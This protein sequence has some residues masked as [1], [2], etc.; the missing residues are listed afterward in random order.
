[1]SDEYNN[2]ISKTFCDNSIR[3]VMMIDD[4]FLPYNEFINHLGNSPDIDPEILDGTKRAVKLTNFFHAKKLICDVDNGSEHMDEERVRK[5][6]LL[7]LDYHL[8][9]EN[10]K[11]SLE[12]LSKLRDSKHMN[13]VVIYTAEDLDKTWLQITASL[14]GTSNPKELVGT[15]QED[16]WGERTDEGAQLPEEWKGVVST[17][18]NLLEYL[19]TD[20]IPREATK[21]LADL[22]SGNASQLKH[23]IAETCLDEHNV[24]RRVK[25][26]NVH[27]NGGVEGTKWLCIGHV[28]IALC[29]KTNDADDGNLIWATLN[30]ALH[31]W[32]PNFYRLLTSEIQNYIEDGNLAMQGYLEGDYASQAAWLWRVKTAKPE[33]VNTNILD[34]YK[35]LI[36]QI[37][38]HLGQSEDLMDYSNDVFVHSFT[39]SITKPEAEESKDR[40]SW[41]K[42]NSTVLQECSENTFR[43]KEDKEG[44]T[45]NVVHA[46]NQSISSKLFVG[47]NI[48]IGTI[49][50]SV[51]NNSDWYLCVSPS[52]DTVPLQHTDNIS[53][54]LKPHRLLKF[55]HLQTT[56]LEKAI[57]NAAHSKYIFTKDSGNKRIALAALDHNTNLPTIEYA[58]VN[59]HDSSSIIDGE[60]SVKFIGDV[61]SIKLKPIDQLR[62]PYA[63][64]FQAI[65]SHYAGRIGVDFIP[66]SNSIPTPTPVSG[67]IILKGHVDNTLDILVEGEIKLQTEAFLEGTLNIKSDLTTKLANS[68]NVDVNITGTLAVCS[69]YKRGDEMII[70]ST[71]EVSSN[72]NKRE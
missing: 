33:D 15:R 72:E 7:V 42:Y 14:R 38:D 32:R 55:I 19:L 47:K 62:E 9:K 13:L 51:D 1:M 17:P 3:S 44:A 36:E 11:K 41:N 34:M 58:V 31:A 28:F 2:L 26:E 68:D 46:L 61:E 54:R 16:F 29:S 27:I 6:D 49:L 56:N 22:P 30:D 20:S 53:K 18:Q 43:A 48:T 12:I 52:C 66:F 69:D 5:C 8:E 50:N 24:L 35:G 64:R 4:N 37:G 25:K 40:A 71:L 39:P 45:V 21:S 23:A 10:P 60:V 67:D 70:D 59:D 65:A 57:G 63:A